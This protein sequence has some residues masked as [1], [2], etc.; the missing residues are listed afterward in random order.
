MPWWRNLIQDLIPWPDPGK[1]YAHV[2]LNKG[3]CFKL[4]CDICDQVC[5][6]WQT[7]CVLIKQNKYDP[8]KRVCWFYLFVCDSQFCPYRVHLQSSCRQISA[9]DIN[10]FWLF[11]DLH[12]V[13]S[14]VS[15]MVHVNCDVNFT[16]TSVVHSAD[17]YKHG[18][19]STEF[20]SM[21]GCKASSK[22]DA[23]V[24]TKLKHMSCAIVPFTV[25]NSSDW[26]NI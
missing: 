22:N 9:I 26:F 23:G 8:C 21:T 12:L 25:C 14:A 2:I 13:T 7:G 17:N 15:S 6:V 24:S 1:T 10:M 20:P 11:D 5:G 4:A 3:R 16:G 19:Q 18:G